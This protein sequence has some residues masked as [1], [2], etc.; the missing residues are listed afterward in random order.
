MKNIEY[1]AVGIALAGAFFNKWNLPF[2]DILV[3]AGLGALVFFYALIGSIFSKI[4]EKRG[5]S[6][7]F[8]VFSSLVLAIGV[9]SLLFSHLNWSYSTLL[10]II[11]FIALPLSIIFNAYQMSQNSDNPLAKMAVIRSSI[12]L[13]ALIVF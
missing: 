9:L 11:S 12:L 2:G 13:L 1:I 10:A 3:F 5:S 8:S 4:Q 7:P 6:L